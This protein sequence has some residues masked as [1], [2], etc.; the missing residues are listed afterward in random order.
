MNCAND[1]TIIPSFDL[2]TVPLYKSVGHK[3]YD[4]DKILFPVATFFHNR[5]H[6]PALLYYH[7][8]LASRFYDSNL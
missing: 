2:H 8:C 3:L 7:S 6:S 5:Y 4:L 1:G